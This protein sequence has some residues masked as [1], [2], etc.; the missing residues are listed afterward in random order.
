MTIFILKL[1]RVNLFRKMTNVLVLLG[2]GTVVISESAHS[3][4]YSALSTNSEQA[5]LN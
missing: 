1:L 3:E 2:N 4:K 5:T